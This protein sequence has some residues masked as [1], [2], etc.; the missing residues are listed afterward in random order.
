MKELKLYSYD[1]GKNR[2]VFVGSYFP[3]K[4]IFYKKVEPIHF[5]RKFNGYGIQFD[6]IQE[7]LR[8]GCERIAIRPV[9]EKV[10]YLSDIKDWENEEI[11]K[12]NYGH[13]LQVFRPVSMMSERILK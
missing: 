7:L 11:R 2:K 13:G 1:G 6:V 3:D 10:A 4:K 12:G 5:M 9:G 8:V